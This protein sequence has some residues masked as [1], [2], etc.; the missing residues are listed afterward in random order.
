M[1]KQKEKK[2][3]ESAVMVL[4]ESMNNGIVVIA[5]SQ[6]QLQSDLKEIRT[7]VHRLKSDVRA[8]KTDVS[9]LKTDVKG[10]LSE[11]K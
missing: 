4:L 3:K 5:E 9:K 8:L 2:Y 11:I 6:Q 7:D 10:G 1:G